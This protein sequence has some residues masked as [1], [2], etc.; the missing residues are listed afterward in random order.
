MS[1]SVQSTSPMTA[2]QPQN[3]LRAPTALP[4]AAST[5]AVAPTD[6]FHMS[7]QPNYQQPAVSFQQEF[8]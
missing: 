2:Y 1:Y 4:V 7:V 6:S 5:Q 8:H 3:G